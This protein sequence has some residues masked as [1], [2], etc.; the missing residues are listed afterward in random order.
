MKNS[1]QKTLL[2][3]IISYFGHEKD[4]ILLIFMGHMQNSI[5]I[6]N[7]PENILFPMAVLFVIA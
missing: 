7:T 2:G 1:H 3:H 5:C 4:N 6:L